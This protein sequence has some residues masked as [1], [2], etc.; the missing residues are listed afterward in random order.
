[1]RHILILLALVLSVPIVKSQDYGNLRVSLLT[2]EPRPNEI[3]TVYGHS[4][5]RLQ[6]D[7]LRMDVVFNWGTF[8][9]TRPFFIYYFLR[10]QT[11]YF[12]STH[13][14]DQFFYSYSRGNSTVVEQVLNFSPE[15]KARLM[16]ILTDNLKEENRNYRYNFLFDNCTT[17]IRD[18]IADTYEGKLH[19]PEQERPLT[20]RELI[21]SCTHP[22]PWMEFGI[23]LVIGN[24]ADSL[25]NLQQEMFLP[26][27][28]MNALQESTVRD[29]ETGS[30]DLVLL[31]TTVM[32]SDDIEVPDNSF[33]TS[34]LFIGILLFLFYLALILIG[35][36][37]GKRFSVFFALLFLLASIGGGIV[38]MLVFFSVHPCVSPNWN[39][40][41]LHPLH[42]IGVIGFF[43]KKIYPLF[44]WYHLVNLVLLCLF[45]LVWFLI[46]Q[47]LD[48]ANIPYIATLAMISG[49]SVYRK[50]QLNK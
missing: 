35:Y 44:Y 36:K 7:S 18:I 38:F 3:Y 17:R 14:Y 20:F 42:I 21:S 28:L 5:L 15:E 41:W 30:R 11:D 32:E 40:V 29:R 34:P 22:Y 37:K 47:Y 6:D 23:N 2:V 24:G 12:L 13:S 9:T 19:Y 31:K 25:V 33:W 16:H 27:H 50:K 8:D 10:G 45:L 39:L 26:E 4:A 49:Y 48:V 1:M 46:P 43:F